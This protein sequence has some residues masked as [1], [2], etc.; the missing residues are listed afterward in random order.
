VV[1]TSVKRT[2]GLFSWFL[3]E[4]IFTLALLPKK[5]PR[6]INAGLTLLSMMRGIWPDLKTELDML[7]IQDEFLVSEWVQ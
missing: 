6:R 5:T 1:Y 2:F 4:M 3:K 7:T